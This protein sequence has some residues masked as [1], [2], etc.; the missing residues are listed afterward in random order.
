MYN[1][2]KKQSIFRLALITKNETKQIFALYVRKVTKAL[3]KLFYVQAVAS[4]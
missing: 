2:H 3:I 1:Q 4:Q